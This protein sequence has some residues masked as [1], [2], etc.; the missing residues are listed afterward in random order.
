MTA[1]R[2]VLAED[3]PM[4]RAGFR[5]LLDSTSD[6]DVVGEAATGREALEQVHACRPDVV[7]MDI[8]MPE[9]DGLEATRR[10]TAADELNETHVLVLTT[11]ELDEYVFGALDA[12]ASGFL[13]KGG[14]HRRPRA[15][16]PDSGKRRGAARPDRDPAADRRLRLA[17]TAAI[18]DRP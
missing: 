4:V 10:I 12:G 9:M 7:V 3:Q 2:V 15:R 18:Q 17:T 6:I 16:D 1:V 13:L 14:E 11:F 5:A 8:R